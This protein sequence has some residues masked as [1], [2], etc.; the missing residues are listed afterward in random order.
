VPAE[1]QQSDW[2]GVIGR[3]LAF[4]CLVQA[5]LRDKDLAPQASFLEAL[6]VSRRESARLL[7]TSEDSL[8]VLMRRAKGAK[9]GASRGKRKGR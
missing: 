4:L 6:G 5:D 7:G 1:E 3:S 9:K 2:L 8:R